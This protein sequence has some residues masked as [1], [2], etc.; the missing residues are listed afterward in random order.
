MKSF[1]LIA[2]LTIAGAAFA[3]GADLPDNANGT[4]LQQVELSS[5]YKL[6]EFDVS[7]DVIEH[8]AINE[9]T[10]DVG[11]LVVH[12]KMLVLVDAQ[13]QQIWDKTVSIEEKKSASFGGT[14]SEDTSNL[15]QG[16]DVAAE[17]AKRKAAAQTEAV[18]YYTQWYNMNRE[19]MCATAPVNH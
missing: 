12:Q 6:P 1:I 11:Y 2:I 16:S 9:Y 10:I 7:K 8:D 3:Q 4:V 13:G 14:W 5:C 15:P 19:Y 17:I 18:T